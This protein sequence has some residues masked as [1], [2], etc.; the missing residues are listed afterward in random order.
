VGRVPQADSAM[1]EAVQTGASLPEL[2]KAKQFL[3]FR[4]AARDPAGAGIPAAQVQEVLEKEPH[5]LVALA[6]SGVLSERQGDLAQ[7][8]KTYEQILAEYP[9]FSP[10]M[11]QLAFIY[12]KQTGN[13]AKAYEL[14]EKAKSAFPDDLDL[15][16]TLGI[17]AYRKAEYRESVRLLRDS[18]RKF[19]NDGEL[20]YY[21]GMD[22]Y[23]LKQRK[24][25][26]ESLQRALALNVPSPMDGEAK[27]VLAELK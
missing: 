23:Q 9:K 2:D 25:S 15:A 11:R 12:A 4:A 17:L 26:K 7:A 18:S 14:A 19:D 16:R 8:A 24:E 5:N 1:E 3:A 6:L 20:S 21:L 13:D 27:R 22:Y 10:A